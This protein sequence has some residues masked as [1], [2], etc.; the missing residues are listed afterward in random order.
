MI[1]GDRRKQRRAEAKGD[2]AAQTSDF[3]IWTTKRASPEKKTRENKNTRCFWKFH[4]P[5]TK[6]KTTE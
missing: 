3:N 1:S 5:R 4:P 2:V 6:K